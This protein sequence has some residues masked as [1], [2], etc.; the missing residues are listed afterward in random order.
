[1][2]AA[3]DIH[4]NAISMLL[5]VADNHTRALDSLHDAVVPALGQRYP[6]I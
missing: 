3:A 6:I 2:E 1:M 4:E 5:D